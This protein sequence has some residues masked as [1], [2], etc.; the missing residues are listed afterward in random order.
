MLTLLTAVLGDG[1][2][3][4]L[5]HPRAKDAREMCDTAFRLTADAK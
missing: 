4:W 5:E 2:V 3:E 1:R